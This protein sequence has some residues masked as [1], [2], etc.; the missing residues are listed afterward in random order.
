MKID[1][2]D[3]EIL[4]L[5]SEIGVVGIVKVAKEN[6]MQ[7]IATQE[8]EIVQVLEKDDIIAV[9]SLKG[10]KKSIR[11]LAYLTREEDS[12]L[13]ILNKN[14]PSTKRLSTVVSVGDVVNL[15]CNIT[16]GTH[17]E[18]TVLCTT[19]ELHD[20]EIK[21]TSTG[22]ELNRDAKYTIEKF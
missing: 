15:N 5:E 7:F 16:P 1:L 2:K 18:Q 19:H 21:K 10:N 20:L 17:P 4:F 14:H 22:I 13:V 6:K 9:S 12:P 11:A 3:D 8:E